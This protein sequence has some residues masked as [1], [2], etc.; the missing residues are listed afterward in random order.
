MWIDCQNEQYCSC[1]NCIFILI[2][3][4]IYSAG[5][6]E[7]ELL[8]KAISEALET[9]D[10]ENLVNQE[11]SMGKSSKLKDSLTIASSSKALTKS[12]GIAS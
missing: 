7:N 11:S 10:I 6:S 1:E 5:L 2:F 4:S 12:T 3:F 9:E 8:E